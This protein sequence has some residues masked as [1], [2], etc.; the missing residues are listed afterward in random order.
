[1]LAADTFPAKWM[2]V[3]VWSQ[4]TC[5]FHTGHLFF[6]VNVIETLELLGKLLN[7]YLDLMIKSLN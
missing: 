3:W 7:K 2:I 1:M 4:A 5:K 6:F